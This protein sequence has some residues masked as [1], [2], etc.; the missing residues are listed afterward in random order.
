M[1]PGS[2]LQP[3][4]P[5]VLASSSPRRREILG[6]MGLT[7]ECTHPRIDNEDTF[8]QDDAIP[9]SIARLADAKARSVATL[10]PDALVLGAD[11]VV[12]CD[13]QIL[14]KPRDQV[15]ARKML[16]MLS[17]RSHEVYSGVSLVSFSRSFFRKGVTRTRVFF[18][19]LDSRDIEEYLDSGE[20]LDKAGAYGIQGL[21][22]LFIDR[23]E[24]CYYNVVGLPVQL[25]RS[26]LNDFST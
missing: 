26:M 16:S 18:R 13:R 23:I 19:R 8:F 4:C 21:A 22:M 5:F 10:Q 2:S 17:G 1:N 11:T 20:H 24:G 3:P 14:A 9:S 7:F 6:K 12:V 15:D 25:T